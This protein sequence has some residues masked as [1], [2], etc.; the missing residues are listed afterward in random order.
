MLLQNNLRQD[1]SS[2]LAP[3]VSSQKP[4]SKQEDD[5][6]DKNAAAAAELVLEHVGYDSSAVGGSHVVVRK[7]HDYISWDDYFMSVAALSSLRSK[8]PLQPAG[9]CL[10]DHRHRIV[11]IGYNGFPAHCSDDCLPWSS[12][13]SSSFTT[14]DGVTTQQDR[15]WL[16]TKYPYVCHAEVNAI[17]NKCSADIAER[18]ARLYVLDFPCTYYYSFIDM[19]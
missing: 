7:R 9:C 11:G 3:P 12:S 15:I 6:D 14:K 16:H 4:S 13:L 8:D 2:T 5:D 1:T 18:G 17:L 10:V 19:I